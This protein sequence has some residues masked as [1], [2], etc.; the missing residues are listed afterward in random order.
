MKMK[1][2]VGIVA[3][4]LTFAGAAFAAECCDKAK[5]EGKTCEKCHPAKSCCDKA[6]AK[7]EDCKHPC[8][9]EAKAAGKT[10]EKCNKPKCDKE[11]KKD[12]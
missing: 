12:A 4:G 2:L 11:A 6:K 9:V 3:A 1:L 8:C 7:G 5:A 10:C